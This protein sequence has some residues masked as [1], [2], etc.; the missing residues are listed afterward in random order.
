M[1]Y[2]SVF[3]TLPVGDGVINLSLERC[4]SPELF[5]GKDVAVSMDDK[6]YKHFNRFFS[7]LRKKE[8]RNHGKNKETKRLNFKNT[9]REK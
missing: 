8:K 7:M 1:F 4:V 6:V 5:C 9:Q 3:R 2:R